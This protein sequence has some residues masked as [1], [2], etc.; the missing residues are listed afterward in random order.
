[1]DE[2][3][4]MITVAQMRAARGL[5]DWSQA[6]LAKQAGLSTTAMNNIDR[7]AAA[8][9]ASTLEKIRRVFEAH[10]VEFTDGSGV[11]LKGEVFRVTTFEGPEGFAAYLRDVLE[12]QI[13]TRSE[14]LHQS[15]DEPNFTAR[16]RKLL[17]GF[18]TAFTQHKLRERVLLREGALARYAPPT[19][20]DYRWFPKEIAGQ[21]GYSVYGDK[22]CIFLKKRILCIENHDLA[23]AYRRQFE[24]QWKQ[25]KKMPAVESLFEKEQRAL[26]K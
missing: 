8:A 3:L 23:E 12:T 1:M 10:G 11:R 21:V 19:T 6:E 13:A 4:K 7:G 14:S 2:N 18:Y 25:A 26:R 16:H 15:Y 5:L 24:L 20:S 17:F 9:R 22:Y